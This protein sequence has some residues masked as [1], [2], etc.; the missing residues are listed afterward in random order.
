M[1]VAVRINRAPV[2][3]LWAAVV[4]ERLGFDHDEA[5]SL[6]RAVAGLN[7]QSK[8]RRLGV[9]RPDEE[10]AEAARDRRDGEKLLVEVCGRAVPA[11]VTRAGLRAVTGGNRVDPARAEAYLRGK[12]GDDL[13]AVRAAMRKLARSYS[14][15]Q[16]AERAYSLYEHFR[17]DIPAGKAG[18]GARGVLDLDRITDLSTRPVS[19]IRGSY[20]PPARRGKASRAGNG[21]RPGAS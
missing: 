10:K 19:G 3:T 14:P 20:S 4:A 11:V 21:P 2:L 1:A 15:R 12:F 7:A 18:W 16:L 13:P 5:L 9:F 6:G 8:G 17:P